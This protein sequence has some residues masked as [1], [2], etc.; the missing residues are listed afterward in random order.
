MLRINNLELQY[1]KTTVLKSACE[2]KLEPNNLVLLVGST[3]SGKT[4]LLNALA[5]I[6]P[7]YTGGTLL[8]SIDFENTKDSPFKIGYVFQNPFEG[9]VQST[10]ASEIA[11]TN[12]QFGV[13]VDSE[14]LDYLLS[15]LDLKQLLERDLSTLSDGEAQRVA[16]AAALCPKPAVLLLDEPTSALHHEAAETLRD[17][18]I[19]I[20]TET[21][22][23]IL[24][25]EHRFENWLES[26]DFVWEVKNAQ[27]T[28]KETAD[29]AISNLTNL[30]INQT[31]R[32]YFPDSQIWRT[33]LAV[34]KLRGITPSLK[35]IQKSHF[36]SRGEFLQASNLEVSKAGKLLLSEVSAEFHLNETVA[37]LGDSG[38]GKSTLL[39]S[40]IG[41]FVPTSGFVQYKNK[42]THD[43]DANDLLGNIA[44]VPQQPGQLFVAETVASECNFADKWRGLTL[45]TTLKVL[46]HFDAGI[47]LDSHP[48]DLSS[49]QQLWLAIAI[50]TA[51]K[52]N[53]LLLDE[54]TRGLDHHGMCLLQELI[55][56]RKTSGL[57]TIWATHDL[58]AAAAVSDRLLVLEKS[59]LKTF[60]EPLARLHPS[61]RGISTVQELLPNS[62]ALSVMQL[63]L[64]I[65][66]A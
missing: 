28:P 23:A 49:G 32:T 1:G 65:Q 47:S 64:E 25:S 22:L 3:G 15:T 58:D 21:N 44:L 35:P 9:F 19:K 63:N 43:L 66:H 56:T 31:V 7:G 24:I 36:D 10:V 27:I 4:T 39:H 20:K 29:F 38:A 46:D 61:L 53:V 33:S 48:R 6:F 12:I 14:W 41:D 50:A 16:I 11:F 42:S 40:L 18:L 17:L 54:P 26:A 5:G 34:E 55:L 51:I 2:L 59:K 60:G 52:P 30:Q 57:A 8:G 37:I 13:P 45:G 62:D